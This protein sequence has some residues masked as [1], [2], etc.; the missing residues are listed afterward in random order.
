MR[1]GPSDAKSMVPAIALMLLT[2]SAAV[3]DA[4]HIAPWH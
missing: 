3:I 2:T 4:I 1:Y